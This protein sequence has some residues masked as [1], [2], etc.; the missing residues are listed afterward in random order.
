MNQIKSAKMQAKHNIKIDPNTEQFFNL[1]F[2]EGPGWIEFRPIQDKKQNAFPDKKARRWFSSSK[3]LMDVYPD[4]IEY[5]L[6]NYLGCFYGVLP[7]ESHGVKNIS[8]PA[9][10]AGLILMLNL[11]SMAG[12][13]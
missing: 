12:M 7:R 1:L 5:C 8:S 13:I 3:K 2:P 6:D 4:M 9:M 10:L 11:M